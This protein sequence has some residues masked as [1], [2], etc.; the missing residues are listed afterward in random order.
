MRVCRAPRPLHHDHWTT[1]I[2]N[3]LFGLQHEDFL[4]TVEKSSE[5]WEN[6]SSSVLNPF[7]R[8]VDVDAFGIDDDA[9]LVHWRFVTKEKSQP[10]EPVLR[11]KGEVPAERSR[12]SGTVQRDHRAHLACLVVGVNFAETCAP[13]CIARS[14]SQVGTASDALVR[15]AT[16]RVPRAGPE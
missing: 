10:K 8:T 2:I 9:P 11:Y 14:S 13:T 3:A 15:I 12:R 4:C 16:G 6:I 5:K 7:W 1:K